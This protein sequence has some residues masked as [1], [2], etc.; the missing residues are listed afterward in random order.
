MSVQATQVFGFVATI[1]AGTSQLSPV[2]VGC[3][4]P[5]AS[6]VA[7]RWR[8]PPGPSGTMGVQVTSDGAPV[9][10]QQLGAYIF[11]NDEAHKWDTAGYPDSGA[12]AAPGDHGHP[13]DHSLY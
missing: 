1:P 4:F 5:Q 3:D 12:S 9:I 13:H 7:I 11:A 6:V 8:V 2:T 10:P